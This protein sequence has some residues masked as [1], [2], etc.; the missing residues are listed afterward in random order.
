MIASA[1]IAAGFVAGM[2]SAHA[3][4]NRFLRVVAAFTLAFGSH[5]VLDSIPHS[6]YAGLPRSAIAAVGLL[7]VV[8]SFAI[9]MYILRHRLLPHWPEFLSAGLFGSALPD[10]K[11]IVP[12]FLSDQNARLVEYYGNRLHEGLHAGPASPAFGLAT[13]LVCTILLLAC[14]FALPRTS[15]WKAPAVTRPAG[16]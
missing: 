8:V 7:E 4:K 14:L 5:F 6:D 16:P 1:H 15:V 13:E 3:T 11:F 10:A 12:I 9:G 2:A